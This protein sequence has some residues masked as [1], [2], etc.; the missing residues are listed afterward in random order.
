MFDGL[1]IVQRWVDRRGGLARARCVED[2]RRT[3]LLTWPW[4]LDPDT[5]SKN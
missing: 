1:M 5:R 4:H 3:V 2:E